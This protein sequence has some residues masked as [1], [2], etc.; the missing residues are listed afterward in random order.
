LAVLLTG[1]NRNDVTQLLPLLQAIPPI[2][3]NADDPAPGRRG[4]L[5]A[6]SKS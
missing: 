3:G 1:G 6:R 5:I 2:R 4:A